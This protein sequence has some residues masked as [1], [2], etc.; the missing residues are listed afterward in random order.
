MNKRI[1]GGILFSLLNLL[2][3]AQEKDPSHHLFSIQAGY[4]NLLKSS[5]LLTQNTDAYRSKVRDGLAWNASYYFQPIPALGIGMLYTGQTSEAAHTEGSDKLYTH[6]FAPQFAVH[7]VN[8]KRVTLGLHVGA[9]ILSYR[10]YSEVFGKDR[11]VKSTFL[12]FNAGLKAE[13]KLSANW[14]IG[15]DCLLITSDMNESKVH[16][17]DE[18]VDVHQTNYIRPFSLTAGLNYRF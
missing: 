15:V 16:Y 5:K 11:T 14:G 7:P 17:H 12:A 3:F 10:N 9:G 18:T 13:Y 1:A 2:A 6:Y 4:G 8:S